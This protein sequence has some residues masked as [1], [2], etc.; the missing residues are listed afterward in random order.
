MNLVGVLESSNSHFRP[1]FEL[2]IQGM[3]GTTTNFDFWICS[4]LWV[5]QIRIEAAEVALERLEMLPVVDVE[6]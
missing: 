1:V 2:Q 5:F 6:V 3:R 4:A